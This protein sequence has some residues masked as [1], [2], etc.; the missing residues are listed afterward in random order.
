MGIGISRRGMIGSPTPG[1]SSAFRE[2]DPAT[3]PP[4]PRS[5]GGVDIDA[6]SV[7]GAG[8]VPGVEFAGETVLAWRLVRPFRVIR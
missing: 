6:V 1:D 3:R 5:L 2:S 4:S 8:D 7:V